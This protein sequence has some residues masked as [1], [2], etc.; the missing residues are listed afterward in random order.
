MNTFEST[1]RRAL[2]RMAA[3]SF[4]TM[5]CVKGS[6][7]RGQLAWAAGSPRAWL[8]AC[9]HRFMEISLSGWQEASG[10]TSA[11]RDS[12][13]EID[14]SQRIQSMLGFGGA[15]TGSSCFLFN[16][17]R[18]EA[19]RQLL[20]ELFSPAGLNLSVARTGIG[21]SDYSRSAYTFDDTQAPNPGLTHFS[22]EHDRAYILPTL[23][24]AASIQPDLFFFSTPWSPP[25]W[26][27]NGRLAS[28]RLHAEAALRF[29]RAILRQV[30]RC[31]QRRRHQHS[32]RH[33]SKRSRHRSGRQN[34]G[35]SLGPGVRRRVHQELPRSG[36]QQRITGHENLAPTRSSPR[37]RRP[38]RSALESPW[39]A[40]RDR[41]SSHSARGPAS[42]PG[43]RPARIRSQTLQP[44]GPHPT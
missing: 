8:T 38:C 23:R 42:A 11:V 7:V 34:A 20:Q 40:S 31:L 22:I 21:S 44:T 6:V 5:V 2:L 35:C 3:T 36:T 43:P 4:A 25:A 13:I 37:R 18:P 10:S 24:E 41:R 1:S 9:S 15:F 28:R 32:R 19:R 30:H 26:M 14:P 33:H 29:L 39:P 12:T 27:K 17:M 16:R